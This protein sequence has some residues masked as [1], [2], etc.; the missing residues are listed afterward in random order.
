MSDAGRPALCCGSF[1]DPSLPGSGGTVAPGADALLGHG[2]GVVRLSCDGEMRIDGRVRADGDSRDGDRGALLGGAAGGSVSLR[3]GGAFRLGEAAAI[4]ADGGDAFH[5]GGGGGGGGRIAIRGGEGGL[6]PANYPWWDEALRRRVHA[7]GGRG[8]MR[9]RD[10]RETDSHL[11]A[12]AGTIYGEGS[13]EGRTPGSGTLVVADRHRPSLAATRLPGDLD[14]VGA[15]A[16]RDGALVLAE[17]S[18]VTLSGPMSV[19]A[20]GFREGHRGALDLNGSVLSAS[21]TWT[22]S[23]GNAIEDPGSYRD[24]VDVR[25]NAILFNGGAVQ[26]RPWFP[27]AP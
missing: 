11:R 5:D 17:T 15:E 14:P 20:L 1:L 12:A 27:A 16:L 22:R 8:D 2:G 13:G 19:R 25:F 4:S 9:R 10:A 24:N 18:Y 26:L 7:W 21:R 6:D 23:P 3:A